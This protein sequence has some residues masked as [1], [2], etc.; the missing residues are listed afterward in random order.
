GYY[1]DLEETQKVFNTDGWL[2]TGDIGSFSADGFLK[3]TDRKKELFKTSGGKY[4]A[5]SPIE[6]KL[7][8]SIYI[9]QV[10]L[11]GDGEKFIAALIVPDFE[12][13]K[14][15]AANNNI[16]DLNKDNLTQN[17]TVRQLYKDIITEFNVNFGKVEQV[18]QFE[19]LS[20]E[21]TPENGLLTATMKLRRKMIKEKYKY[22][23]N[24]FYNKI[25]E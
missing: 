13:L 15:W 11:V 14:E 5:P 16:S 7:K 24:I 6:N 21:W 4:V 23:I 10:A 12:N 18:K 22:L 25:T 19:L 1:K 17:T 9:D 2:L 8:E 3:I 20:D